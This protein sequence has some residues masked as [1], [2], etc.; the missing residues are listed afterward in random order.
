MVTHWGGQERLV[1]ISDQTDTD[2]TART[3]VN[4]VVS[5]LET[6]T[7]RSP[8]R[9]RPAAPKG[10]SVTTTPDAR[11]RAALMAHAIRRYRAAIDADNESTADNVTGDNITDNNNVTE[12]RNV[13]DKANVEKM[14]ITNL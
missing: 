9:H 1:K 4:N 3:R 7:S 12:L 2:E 13:I 14:P 6:N 8:Q 10:P 11:L 5:I